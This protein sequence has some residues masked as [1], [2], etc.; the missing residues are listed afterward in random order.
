MEERLAASDSR[1]AAR[2]PFLI[3]LWLPPLG[4]RDW[5]LAVGVWLACRELNRGPGFQGFWRPRYGRTTPWQ[6]V[7]FATGC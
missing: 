5:R 4:G 7:A 6:P 2:V 3:L 1:F